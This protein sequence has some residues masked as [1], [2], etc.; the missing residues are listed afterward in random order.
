VVL[1]PDLM[2]RRVMVA[3]RWEPAAAALAPGPRS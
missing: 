3:G 1:E 2:V